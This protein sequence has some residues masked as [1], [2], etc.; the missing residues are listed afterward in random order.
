M[1]STL[2]QQYAMHIEVYSH[3]FRV[4]R[5]DDNIRR[6]LVELC[7]KYALYESER[8]QN[9]HYV[10]SI[11]TVFAAATITRDQYFFHRNI[12]ED[13]Y[14]HMLF[15]GIRPEQIRRTDR[16][17]YLPAKTNLIWQAT[18]IEFYGYQNDIIEFSDKPEPRT[19]MITLQA[20][21]GKTL[22]LLGFINHAQ[23]RTA[24][25]MKPMYT[26]QWKKEILKVFEIEK[27]DFYF[28]KGSEALKDLIMMAKTDPDFNPGIILISNATYRI[29]LRYY[30]DHPHTCADVFGCNPWE[31]F[32]ILR[33]GI[34]GL[35]EA[36]QEFHA[37]FLTHCVSNVYKYVAM[38]ATMVSGKPGM[39]KFY[40]IMF[41]PDTYAP[42]PPLVKY[43]DVISV[44]YRF[45]RPDHVRYL[46]KNRYNHGQFEKSIMKR[47]RM[48]LNYCKM[49]GDMV[50]Y[51]FFETAEYKP[52]QKIL[53]FCDLVAMCTHVQEH[54]Q[55]MFPTKKVV[56]FCGSVDP[57]SN[58]Y[59]D[60][61]DVIVT[62]LK[63]CGTARDIANVMV[64]LCTVATND[65]QQSEQLIHRLREPKVGSR[66]F[67]VTP[68]F[69]F[70]INRDNE[71]HLRYYEERHKQLRH[72]VK[73][74]NQLSSNFV[75]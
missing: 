36:H 59:D 41:P 31:F 22:S 10:T 69:I 47:K 51:Q 18:E 1:D 49:T 3:G 72:V 67:G 54:L 68:R 75:V 42:K 20:G 55:Q 43:I 4:S 33:I 48:L 66:W 40:R 37:N 62:T 73:N 16:P 19:K 46:L 6:L 50:K 2:P 64:C 27:G 13:F 57:E 71:K 45:D 56:R 21:K 38:S 14:E 63:S 52:G 30:F 34:L 28:V 15:H 44:F 5:F 70:L 26:K 24:L 12:L 23:L 53:V 58:L 17:M 61:N 11:K 8:D 32:E 39:N 9:G 29:F 65:L 35:D 25:I 60:D 74:F 7:R